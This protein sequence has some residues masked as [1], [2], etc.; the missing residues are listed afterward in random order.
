M[1]HQHSL[2]VLDLFQNVCRFFP[3]NIA[4]Q[5]GAETLSY[6]VLDRRSS[7]LAK[8]LRDNGV[9]HSQVIP[10]ITNSCLCMVVGIL[11]ILKAGAIYTPIDRE[12][13][14]KERIVDVLRRTDASIVVYTGP[15]VD[16]PSMVMIDAEENE[17]DESLD[18]E[19]MVLIPE[20]AAL[21][22][23]SGTTGKPK[24]V[25]IK[26]SSLANFVTSPHFNYDV[27]PEDR[28]LLVLSVA[29]DGK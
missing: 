21:I 15:K 10:L 3:N 26:H 11:A 22:F 4:V 27:T 16:L 14:P 8:R 19:E 2:S 17:I 18:D 12:Q 1:N 25:E 5:D 20:L 9:R 23:T 6:R 24:G 28:V 7:A 13:W 29:F